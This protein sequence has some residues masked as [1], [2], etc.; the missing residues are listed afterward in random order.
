MLCFMK[1][2]KMTVLMSESLKPRLDIS[3]LYDIDEK[4]ISD[5]MLCTIET[6]SGGKYIANLSSLKRTKD[7][8]QIEVKF[9]CNGSAASDIVFSEIESFEIS[10]GG[11]QIA[12]VECSTGCK[13]VSM[14]LISNGLYAIQLVFPLG[15]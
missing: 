9:S 8:N 1:G 5:N 15:Q 13:S 10:H 7:P 6:D 12:L 4:I 2:E 14:E 3:E 11:D